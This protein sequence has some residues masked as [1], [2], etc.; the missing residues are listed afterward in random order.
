MY[1][2]RFFILMNVQMYKFKSSLLFRLGLCL[3]A[4]ML[5]IAHAHA[6]IQDDFNDGNFS[7]NPAWYGDISQFQISTDFMLQSMADSLPGSSN[8]VYLSTDAQLFG[9]TQWDFFANPKVETSSNNLMD[10]YLMADSLNLKGSL[11]GYFVRIGGTPDE[12]ALFRKDGLTEVKIIAGQQ[13]AI[14]SGS[15][16]PTRVRVIRKQDGTWTLFADYKG[17]GN[18]YEQVGF[19][20]D[21]TYSTSL[22]TGVLIKYSNKNR[23]KYFFDDLMIQPEQVDTLAPIVVEVSV[24]NNREIELT[25]SEN[26]DP[27]SA[28]NTE[29]YFVNHGVGEPL[30]ATR[31]LSLFQR[32]RLSF[33]NSFPEATEL[34]ITSSG[35]KDLAGN[36]EVSAQNIFVYYPAKPFDI[37]IN[38]VM[39]DPDPP[40]FLPNAEYIELF[41]RTPHPISLAG[42]SIGAGSNFKALPATK[43]LP[44][45]FLVLSSYSGAAL[46]GDSIAVAAVLAFPSLTN[47]G[48]SLSLLDPEGQL[49]SSVNYSDSWYGNTAKKDGGWSLEQISPNQPCAGSSNWTASTDLRGGTPGKRNSVYNPVQDT[50]AP[51]I[52]R[53]AVVSPDTIRVFFTEPVLATYAADTN[54]YWIDEG[55]GKPK[56]VQPEAPDFKTAKLS[57][58]TPIQVGLI[59]TLSLSGQLFDC[60]GNTSTGNNSAVFAIPSV[61]LPGDIV[62][63]EILS[64]PKAG[65]SDYIEL[66]NRSQKI[67]DLGSLQLGSRDTISNLNTESKPIAPLGYLCFPGQYILL[68]TSLTG[69]SPF[70]FV[71]GDVSFIPMASLAAYNNESGIVTLSRIADQTR[72]DEVIYRKEMHFEFLNSLDGVSLERIH[73]NRPSDDKSNWNSAASTVRYGTPGYKNSQFNEGVPAENAKLSISPEVFSPDNDG[74]DDVLTLSYAFESAGFTGSIAIYD[75][76]GRP[77]KYLARNLLLGTS[78]EVSWNGMDENHERA[79]MGIYIAYLEAFTL[80]G[81][82]IAVKKPFVLG[83]KF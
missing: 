59:Y 68:S 16:N 67:I 4:S 45:S 7:E 30:S 36:V 15:N 75:A 47:T 10:I 8:T 27:V 33:Q 1:E 53:V 50:L 69:I 23:Q 72:I 17:I 32:V 28:S 19:V 11:K 49:I 58:R 22:F 70:Y 24:I 60:S 43:I 76:S 57:L 38:E 18:Q 41:N 6:Q 44:D 48:A 65:G 80:D 71:P 39:A 64:D 63:N 25:Y 83:G 61:C 73:Y 2:F 55:I 35:V 31:D 79:R 54:A 62:I 82:T 12:V 66:V 14:T 52:A 26:V 40:V 74:Y 3:L 77:I 37:V 5:F 78:G 51:G 46:Y 9:N 13:G 29:N 20:Q 34:T 42:W 21:Q 56:S 81:K